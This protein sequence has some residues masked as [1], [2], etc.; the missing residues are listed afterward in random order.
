VKHLPT[1]LVGP[2]V[3]DLDAIEAEWPVI[4]A[5]M[6]LLDAEIRVLTMDG[7]PAPIDWQRLRRAQAR[8][9]R[10]AAELSNHDAAAPMWRAA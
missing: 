6:A 5:E 2:T 4:E 10:I 3:A 9:L 8:V 7:P 1:Q